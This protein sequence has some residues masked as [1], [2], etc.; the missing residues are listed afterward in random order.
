MFPPD[1]HYGGWCKRK[2]LDYKEPIEG[3]REHTTLTL[4]AY[5]YSKL[6]IKFVI[7]RVYKLH[8]KELYS[9]GGTG[10]EL[11]LDELV[12]LKNEMEKIIVNVKKENDG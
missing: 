8:N 4:H 2:S 5:A 1:K 11:T 9:I 10:F 12:E 3:D 7:E 6:I